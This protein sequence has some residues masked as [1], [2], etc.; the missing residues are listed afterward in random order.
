MPRGSGDSLRKYLESRRRALRERPKLF[1]EFV[2]KLIEALGCRASIIVFGG[3]ARVGLDS[4]EPR[5]YDVLV[6][7]E[8]SDDV[9]QVEELVHRLRPRGVPMDI[10]V[11]KRSTLR[12]AIA[13]QM[14]KERTVVHDP[15]GIEK[16][17]QHRLEREAN[18]VSH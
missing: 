7:L 10:I 15:L 3:R 18:S 13:K 17:L 12:S 9:E 6:V 5:D 11:V 8:D 1:R 2:E 14:L 16:E 4:E